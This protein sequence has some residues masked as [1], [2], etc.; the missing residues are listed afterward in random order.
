MTYR[1]DPKENYDLTMYDNAYK[2]VEALGGRVTLIK[3]S[4]YC[5]KIVNIAIGGELEADAPNYYRTLLHRIMWRKMDAMLYAVSQLRKGHQMQFWQFYWSNVV[6]S[7]D[8]EIEY[9]SLQKLNSEAYPDEMK[10]MKIAYDY[11]YDGINFNEGYYLKEEKSPMQ[12]LIE[13]N[14]IPKQKYEKFWVILERNYITYHPNEK[15]NVVS[16]SLSPVCTDDKCYIKNVLG[17]QDGK[18]SYKDGKCMI[19][20][21][22]AFKPEKKYQILISMKKHENIYFPV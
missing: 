11:F 6:K 3:D 10:I 20:I 2:H 21:G 13:E 7:K 15:W 16:D 22:A 12:K 8:L 19:A 18:L 14:N 17:L 5:T 4:V 1:F 9:N